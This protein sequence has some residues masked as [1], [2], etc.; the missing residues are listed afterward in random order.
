M[1]IVDYDLFISNIVN[2]NKKFKIID[3][4]QLQC[5]IPKLKRQSRGKDIGYSEPSILFE[6]KFSHLDGENIYFSS[7]NVNGNVSRELVE[8]YINRKGINYTI[9]HV[10]GDTKELKKWNDFNIEI[11]E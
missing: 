4:D 3:V 5:K 7:F 11:I 1:N 9:T 10:Y 8:W 2:E 6:Y